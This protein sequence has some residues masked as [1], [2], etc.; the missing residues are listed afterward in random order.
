MTTPPKAVI[1]GKPVSH[2]R[3]PL[4]HGFWLKK[5]GLEGRYDRREVEPGSVAKAFGMF[6]LEGYRGG[7]VTVPHKEEAFAACDELTE[8]ARIA[9][10]VNTFWFEDGRIHGDN[11]DGSG[12]VAHLDAT[13]PGWDAKRPNILVVGAGGAARG[14]IVPLLN[15]PVGEVTIVNRS[16]ERARI[17]SGDIAQ[18]RPGTII[19]VEDW[20]QLGTLLSKTDVLINTTSLGMKG[21]PSL[22]LPLEKLPTT[23]IVADI[24]YVPLETS[25]LAAARARGLRALDGLG[26]LLHQ[27]VPGFE[28]WFGARPVVDEALRAHIL[29]DLGGS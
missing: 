23:A 29:A 25:L 5:L 16:S 26:M 28:R 3:S 20:S 6:R 18:A 4:I 11:T 14:V 12:F 27:A 17:L 21:Q 15:R 22:S 19:S 2:A 1:I 9:G 24:V 10:A 8:A 13:H 7:N